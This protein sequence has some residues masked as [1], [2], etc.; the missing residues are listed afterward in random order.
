MDISFIY[1]VSLLIIHGRRARNGS[2]IY[3]RGG[4][5][6]VR[7]GLYNAGQLVPV[8][9]VT[10]L[11]WGT[12]LRKKRVVNKLMLDYLSTLA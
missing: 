8:D 10:V 2:L 4:L 9:N 1:N 6:G 7:G 3:T 11:N 5:A 12:V